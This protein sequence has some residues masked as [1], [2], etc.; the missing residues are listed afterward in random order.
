MSIY[1]EIGRAMESGVWVGGMVEVTQ[2]NI[3]LHFLNI[4][5]LG[6]YND[7]ICRRKYFIFIYSSIVIYEELSAPPYPISVRFQF[8]NVFFNNVFFRIESFTC[9]T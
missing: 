5:L 9:K 3:S 8:E 7:A 2:K 6:I 1:I 4:L